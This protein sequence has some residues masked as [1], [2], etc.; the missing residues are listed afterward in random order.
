MYPFS[1]LGRFSTFISS[2]IIFR[3]TLFLL[4]FWDLDNMLD[5]FLIVPQVPEAVF[6]LFTVFFPVRSM[7][8]QI[9]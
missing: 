1:S 3:S 2:S 4:P 8:V 6:V 5:L 9:E 7:S